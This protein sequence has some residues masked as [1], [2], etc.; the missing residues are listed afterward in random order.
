M[1]V[2]NAGLFDDAQTVTSD[3]GTVEIHDVDGTQKL[4][5]DTARAADRISLSLPV[6]GGL[7]S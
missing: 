7:K 3:S 6:K 4:F 5:V 1:L 2:N